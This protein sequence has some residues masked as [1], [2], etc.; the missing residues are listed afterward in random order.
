MTQKLFHRQKIKGIEIVE[1]ACTDGLR[2]FFATMWN[3][4]QKSL[5]QFN[6][7]TVN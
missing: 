4:R 7:I 1:Q 2:V 5:Q 3:F 6:L